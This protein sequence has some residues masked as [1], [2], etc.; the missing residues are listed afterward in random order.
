MADALE[1]GN[2]DE[3]KRAPYKYVHEASEEEGRTRQVSS[4]ASAV[5]LWMWRNSSGPQ[6]WHRQTFAIGATLE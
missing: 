2:D 6:P 1:S 4:D 3:G 5:D